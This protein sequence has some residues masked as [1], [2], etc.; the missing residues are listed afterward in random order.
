MQQYIISSCFKSKKTRCFSL[1]HNDAAHYKLWWNIYVYPLTTCSFV[2]LSYTCISQVKCFCKCKYLLKTAAANSLQCW[3]ALNEVIYMKNEFSWN[4][5]S[6]M[7]NYFDNHSFNYHSVFQNNEMYITRK[8]ILYV[9]FN[10][11]FN[12]NTKSTQC[13]MIF[14]F[15]VY[16]FPKSKLINLHKLQFST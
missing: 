11:Q 3:N 1:H 14:N 13:D 15:S 16:S 5:Q 2:W 12:M 4:H 6:Y 8:I 7:N 9:L 10:C